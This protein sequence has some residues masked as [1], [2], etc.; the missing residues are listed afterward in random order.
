MLAHRPDPHH[1]WHAACS[2]PSSRP[3]LPPNQPAEHQ[4]EFGGEISLACTRCPGIGADDKQA[5]CWQATGARSGHF[6]QPTAHTVA[7]HCAPD[8]PAHHEPNPRRHRAAAARRALGCA[9]RI[10]VPT[11]SHLS[12]PATS[13]RGFFGISDK[14]MH[15]QQRADSAQTAA[16]RKVEVGAPPHPRS[17]R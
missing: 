16:D 5:T 7:N 9:V 11:W 2:W 4:I 10:R 15:G 12:A 3:N 14:K 6:A 1:A 13:R 8:R 17:S